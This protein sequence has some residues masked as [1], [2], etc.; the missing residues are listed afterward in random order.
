MHACQKEEEEEEEEEEDGMQIA[1]NFYFQTMVLHWNDFEIK[2]N[3]I[4]QLLSSTIY[5]FFS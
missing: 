3:P 5:V 1:H 4:W 2:S